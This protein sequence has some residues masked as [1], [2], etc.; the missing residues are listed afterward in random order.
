MSSAICPTCKVLRTN[1][2][3][4]RITAEYHSIGYIVPLACGGENALRNMRPVC[5]ECCLLM[6]GQM[7][8]DLMMYNHSFIYR[9]T[10]YHRYTTYDHYNSRQANYSE[11][12]DR[13]DD[14]VE[15]DGDG[16]C[17]GDGYNG[18][19]DEFVGNYDEEEC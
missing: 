16:D 10:D 15:I 17:D 14:V 9:A 11:F 8:N 6:N 7:T 13:R 2:I 19:R 4:N 5:N 3:G 18:D 12:D 1:K